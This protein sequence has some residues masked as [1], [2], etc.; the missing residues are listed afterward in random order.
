MGYWFLRKDVDWSW[1]ENFDLE[2]ADVKEERTAVEWKVI[3]IELKKKQYFTK[4]ASFLSEED[5]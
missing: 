2:L 4:I 3:D 5:D 1:R